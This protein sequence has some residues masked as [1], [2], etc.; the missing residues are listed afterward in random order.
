VLC[1][2]SMNSSAMGV[3]V[4]ANGCLGSQGTILGLFSQYVIA[5]RRITTHMDGA[6]REIVEQR[7]TTLQQLVSATARH[8]GDVA[9]SGHIPTEHICVFPPSAFAANRHPSDR[10]I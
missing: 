10:S 7:T 4:L 9:W 8:R 5:M 2:S 6:K 1:I 3:R